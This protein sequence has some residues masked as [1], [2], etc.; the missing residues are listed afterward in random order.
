MPVFVA[1]QIVTAAQLNILVGNLAET[2]P[3][4]ATS[5]GQLFVSTGPNAI[6]V[7]TPRT[8]TTT[9]G[10]STSSINTYGD[11]ATVGPTVTVVL[12]QSMIVSIGALIENSVNGGGGNMSFGYSGATT[13]AAPNGEPLRM[14]NETSG[15]AAAS[16]Q[17]ASRVN[18]V[19]GLNTGTH[20]VAGKYTTPTGGTA[21]FTGR[22]IIVIPL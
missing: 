4:K 13:N 18:M 17:A 8:A 10:E 5:A 12:N 19:T 20:A 14:M 1:G 7:V 21:T 3:A 22:N 11:L 16:R 6:S 15:G 2:A 9:V